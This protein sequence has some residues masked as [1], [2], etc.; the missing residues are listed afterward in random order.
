MEEKTTVKEKKQKKNTRKKGGLKQV[1]TN[2][3]VEFGRII[4]PDRDT[5]TKSTAA[6]VVSSVALGIIIAVIDMIIKF[7]L[8]F[9]IA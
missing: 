5:L 7:G 8:G 6:V 2:L 9:V 4:W 3:R 1:L